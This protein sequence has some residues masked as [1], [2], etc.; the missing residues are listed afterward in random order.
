V[1]DNQ[2]SITGDYKGSSG[3]PRVTRY[4]PCIKVISIEEFLFSRNDM[5]QNG[6]EIFPAI[7]VQDFFPYRF[8][9]SKDIED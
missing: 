8:L 6:A 5:P 4:D 7:S 1:T 2:C 9:P 3:K